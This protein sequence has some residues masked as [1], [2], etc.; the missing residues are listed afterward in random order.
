MFAPFKKTIPRWLILLTAF[1]FSW[2]LGAQK[3]VHPTDVVKKVKDNF[4]K[5]NTYQAEFTILTQRKIR[6]N[7]PRVRPILK[8]AAR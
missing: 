4:Y 8:K 1:L 6:K 2:N 5:L 7:L 3:F